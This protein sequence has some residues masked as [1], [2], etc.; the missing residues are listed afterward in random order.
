MQE[1]FTLR[2]R[3]HPPRAGI[4]AR[5]VMGMSLLAFIGGALLIG[6]L[7]WNG[8]ITLAER[9]TPRQSIASLPAPATSPAA[10]VAADAKAAA[11]EQR[12]AALEARLARIDLQAAA[13]EGNTSRAE[14]LLVVLAARRA[15]ERGVALG[16]LEEQLKLRFADAQPK[17]VEAVIAAG[18]KPAS[19]EQL[20]GELERLAPQLA[21]R[22]VDESGWERLTRELSGLFVIRRDS[23][24]SG[25]PEVRLERA[26]LLLRSGRFGEAADEVE[27]LPGASGAKEWIAAARR[28]EAAMQ[29]LNLIENTALLE[30]ARLKSG[31]GKPVIQPSPLAPLPAPKLPANPT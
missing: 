20:A 16:Y 21:D 27:K 13:T 10:L 4:S 23:A 26:Q 30:P 12:V 1:D 28:H 31:E 17:A 19:L 5:A 29:G 14:A 18:A 22:P 7:V 3:I 9:D 15:V 25:Q 6:W 2:S 11:Y 8:K 24:P